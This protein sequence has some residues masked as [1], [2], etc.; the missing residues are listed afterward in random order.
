MANEFKD[1][2]RVWNAKAADALKNQIL[3][4]QF[5]AATDTFEIGCKDPSGNM[6]YAPTDKT[7]LATFLDISVVDWNANQILYGDGNQVADFVF[8]S[9]KVGNGTATPFTGV[10]ISGADFTGKG[11]HIKNTSNPAYL[12]LESDGALANGSEAGFGAGRIVFGGNNGASA[13]QKIMQ[14]SGGGNSITFDGLDDTGAISQP[15]LFMINRS[16]VFVGSPMSFTGNNGKIAWSLFSPNS[17]TLDVG[18]STSSIT[19]LQTAFDGNFYHIDEQGSANPAIDLKVDFTNITHF[20]RI[21]VIAVY[22]GSQSHSVAIQLYNWTQTRWD[23]FDALQHAQEEIT[24]ADSYS[25]ENHDFWINN[26]TE[27]IGTGPDAGKVR[28]RFLHPF[29]GNGAHDLWIDVVK[30][31]R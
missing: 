9:N 10:S 12:I 14:I 27:Y 11:L 7:P 20:N 1:V 17:I 19:D 2:I 18:S 16:G 30:V 24:T 6:M 31:V 26:D 3:T 28:V 5:G 8:I 25:L 15:D 21:N 13:N 23:T 22:K 29:S 4:K